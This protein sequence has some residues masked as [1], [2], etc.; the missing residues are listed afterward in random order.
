MLTNHIGSESEEMSSEISIDINI[1]SYIQIKRQRA[2]CTA[3][4]QSLS[5]L[6][7]SPNKVA[8][9]RQPSEPGDH[10]SVRII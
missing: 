2:Q 3:L 4:R 5:S 8:S 9:R 7:L 1:L 6:F 10:S